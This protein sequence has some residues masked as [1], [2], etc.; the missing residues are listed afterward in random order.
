MQEVLVRHQQQRR[1]VPRGQELFPTGDPLMPAATAATG[2]ERLHTVMKAGQIRHLDRTITPGP[3]TGDRLMLERLHE[4]LMFGLI[5]G[6]QKTVCGPGADVPRADALHSELFDR[7]CQT[8]DALRRLT[9]PAPAAI[10]PWFSR[11]LNTDCL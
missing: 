6:R 7:E 9:G 8:L 3:A 1:I 11:E 4:T 2:F 5:V 10:L